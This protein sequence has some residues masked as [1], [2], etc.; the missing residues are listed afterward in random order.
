MAKRAK[1]TKTTKAKPDPI[2]ASQRARK[3]ELDRMNANER[4]L[5]RRLGQLQREIERSHIA[6][7]A[8]YQWLGV[9]FGFIDETAAAGAEE[10]R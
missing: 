8:F 3:R 7:R 4:K 5:R 9:R 10:S 2:E 6:T 1:T